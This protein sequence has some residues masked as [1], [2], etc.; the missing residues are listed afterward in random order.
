MLGVELVYT[1]L[2]GIDLRL[3]RRLFK[4]IQ[5]VAFFD[6][7]AFNKQSLLEERGNSRYESDSALGL[8]PAHEFIGLC[9]LLPL[10]PNCAYS[11]RTWRLLRNSGVREPTAKRQQDKSYRKA[12]GHLMLRSTDLAAGVLAAGAAPIRTRPH[13]AA[14]FAVFYLFSLITKTD[15]EDGSGAA[16][17]RQNAECIFAVHLFAILHVEYGVYALGMFDSRAIRKVGPVHDPRYRNQLG[18]GRQSSIQ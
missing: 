8:D 14:P 4:L 13:S 3:K 16:Q 15:L 10:G 6:F 17:S 5:E 9:Y 18:E 1:G 2:G 7:R 11:G 12:A